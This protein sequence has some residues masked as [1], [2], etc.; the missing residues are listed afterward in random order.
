MK[1]AKG[2]L[3]LHCFPLGFL[4]FVGFHSFLKEEGVDVQ[5]GSRTNS[6]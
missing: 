3:K 5:L 2:A 6:L 1:Q 4:C